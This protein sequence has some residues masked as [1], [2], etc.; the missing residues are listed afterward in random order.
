M[1]KANTNVYSWGTVMFAHSIIQNALKKGGQRCTYDQGYYLREVAWFLHSN[2]KFYEWIF[3]RLFSACSIND[4]SQCYEL[5]SS[6]M[7]MKS[8]WVDGARTS[9]VKD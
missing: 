7:M 5:V 1:F 6:I 3:Q 4:V 9:Q 8:G 2:F